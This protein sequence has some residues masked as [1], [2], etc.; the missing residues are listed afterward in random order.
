[1]ILYNREIIL[2]FFSDGALFRVNHYCKL[3]TFKGV[4][5][6]LIMTNLLGISHLTPALTSDIKAIVLIFHIF[7][8]KV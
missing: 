7:L 5:V 2:W 1:M 6:C 3:I 4:K 8:F